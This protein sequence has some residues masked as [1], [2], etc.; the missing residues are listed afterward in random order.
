MGTQLPLKG[1]WPLVFGPCLLWQTAGWMKMLLDSVV[2]LGPGDAVLDGD[3]APPRSQLPQRGTAPQFSA[4][5]YCG[6]TAGWI[7]MPLATVVG[8]GPCHIVLDGDPT[9]PRKGAQQLHFCRMII[10]TKRSPISATAELSFIIL[11]FRAGCSTLSRFY[12]NILA[13]VKYLVP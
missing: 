4:Q 13:H 12:Q 7:K 8:L 6:Q 9:P 3:T 5:V 11:Q 10:V 1:A 2:G